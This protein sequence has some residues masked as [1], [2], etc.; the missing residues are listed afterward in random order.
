VMLSPFS[1][2]FLSLSIPSIL[3]RI[4]IGETL[5]YADAISR[6]YTSAGIN[7][8]APLLR[9]ERVFTAHL[10]RSPENGRADKESIHDLSAVC[11]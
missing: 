7:M 9:L 10:Y 8:E 2:Y 5:K 4:P 11:Q 3:L 6:L 1:S